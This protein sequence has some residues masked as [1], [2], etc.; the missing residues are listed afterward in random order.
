MNKSNRPKPCS[1]YKGLLRQF[2]ALTSLVETQGQCISQ[3]NETIR[4]LHEQVRLTDQSEIDAL[5]DT[6]EKLTNELEELSYDFKN[7]R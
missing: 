5:R 4:Q 1:N 3:Q 2:Y 6:N 7:E